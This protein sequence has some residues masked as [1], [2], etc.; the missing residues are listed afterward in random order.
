MINKD[1]LNGRL[2]SV[3]GNNIT[4]IEG[5]EEALSSDEMYVPHHVLE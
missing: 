4:D 5:W 3:Y 2:N 1:F